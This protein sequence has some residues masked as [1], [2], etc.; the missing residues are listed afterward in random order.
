[1]GWVLGALV[2][3]WPGYGDARDEET[4]AM[5]ATIGSV[6]VLGLTVLVLGTTLLVLYR[7]EARARRLAPPPNDFSRQ[8]VAPTA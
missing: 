5:V 8:G 2:W 3:L 7:R 6:M 4:L 1:L